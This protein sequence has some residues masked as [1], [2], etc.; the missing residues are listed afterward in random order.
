[1]YLPLDFKGLK[2]TVM[3]RIG[4]IWLSTVVKWPDV[5]YCE[6]GNENMN[7]IKVGE[8][9]DILNQSYISF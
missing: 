5:G 8:F 7:S 4:L 6:Y 3:M 1:M 9:L 2:Q